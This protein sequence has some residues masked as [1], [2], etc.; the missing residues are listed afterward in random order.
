MRL[1]WAPS[2]L[3]MLTNSHV[4]THCLHL[5]QPEQ[6]RKED[7]M[8][9]E[10]GPGLT[11]SKLFKELQGEFVMFVL[12]VQNQHR[13]LNGF[14][15][16]QFYRHQTQPD[17]LTLMCTCEIMKGTEK[18]GWELHG[19]VLCRGDISSFIWK[20]MV[21]LPPAEKHRLFIGKKKKKVFYGMIGLKCFIHSKIKS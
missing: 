1:M 2:S 7:R 13:M 9:E 8:E 19:G 11:T 21:Q 18:G 17:F 15:W 20:T 3:E 10:M 4:G 12:F 16:E 14:C 5:L 6:S